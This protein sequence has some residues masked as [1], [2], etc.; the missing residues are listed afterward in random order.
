MIAFLTLSASVAAA[1]ICK[2]ELLRIV[3]LAHF[4]YLWPHDEIPLGHI[5]LPDE[6]IRLRDDSSTARHVRL[7]RDEQPGRRRHHHREHL[8][9][10]RKGRGNRHREHQQAQILAQKES[11]RES[12]RLRLHGQEPRPGTVE[13]PQERELHRRPGPV[14]QNSGTLVR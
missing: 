10:T 12:R 7:C 3:R 8:Q 13:A 1:Q 5:R 4:Y 11:R 9:R 2:S 14:P 6:R